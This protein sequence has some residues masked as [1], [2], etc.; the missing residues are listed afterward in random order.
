MTLRVSAC[1][2]CITAHVCIVD[3]CNC[4]RQPFKLWSFVLQPLAQNW[5]LIII[6]GVTFLVALTYLTGTVWCWN[7]GLRESRHLSLTLD[8]NSWS[9]SYRKYTV[10]LIS[11]RHAMLSLLAVVF[12]STAVLQHQRDVVVRQWEHLWGIQ[13]FCLIRVATEKLPTPFGEETTPV[14]F[15]VVSTAHF[16]NWLNSSQE[17]KS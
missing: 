3:P 12:C 17:I 10:Y 1:D 2:H 11:Y 8:H 6:L 16:A 15:V 14:M 4:D 5:F 13:Y 7:L 9:V